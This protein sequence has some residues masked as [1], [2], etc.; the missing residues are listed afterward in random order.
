MKAR[1][2]C[3]GDYAVVEDDHDGAIRPVDRK[4]QSIQKSYVPPR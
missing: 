3:G 4:A 2:L 1:L